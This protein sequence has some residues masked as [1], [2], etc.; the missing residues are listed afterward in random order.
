MITPLSC[1]SMTS[2]LLH[3][4]TEIAQAQHYDVIDGVIT[5]RSKRLARRVPVDISLAE[6][7][8]NVAT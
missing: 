8:G 1:R 5:A 7:T 6:K 3:V 4:E 2:E